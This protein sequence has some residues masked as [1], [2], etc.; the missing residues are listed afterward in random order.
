MVDMV[1]RTFRK[2]LATTIIDFAAKIVD[3]MMILL[4][5]SSFTGQ[6]QPSG[7]YGA[8]QPP[9]QQYGNCNLSYDIIIPYENTDIS[10]GFV[11]VLLYTF[12]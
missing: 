10:A 2:T 11:I 7:S 4:L 5:L 6:S 8:P 1:E 3:Y 12:E 9:S